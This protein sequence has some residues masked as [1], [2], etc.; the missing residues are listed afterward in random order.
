LG[1]G[2][3]AARAAEDEGDG[4]QQP[5]V[6]ERGDH[7]GAAGHAAVPVTPAVPGAVPAAATRLTRVAA[8]AAGH[9]VDPLLF[10]GQPA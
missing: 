5:G 2:C 9:P 8:P 7:V 3:V 1:D 6:V 4:G 10:P